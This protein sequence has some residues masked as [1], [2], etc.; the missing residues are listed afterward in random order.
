MSKK[1]QKIYDLMASI[2][3]NTQPSAGVD[4]FEKLLTEIQDSPIS[5]VII[6]DMNSFIGEFMIL[7]KNIDQM[8]NVVLKA[9]MLTY[10]FIEPKR[11]FTKTYKSMIYVMKELSRYNTGFGENRTFNIGNTNRLGNLPSFNDNR[12]KQSFTVKY[13][14]SDEEKEQI[15]EDIRKIFLLW[16]YLPAIVKAF[17]MTKRRSLGLDNNSKK[18]A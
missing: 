3:K 2:R 4:V 5:D 15:Y 12:F 9:K 18:F 13:E 11:F 6:S 16:N 7:V 17:I 10:D 1:E 8:D 14:C